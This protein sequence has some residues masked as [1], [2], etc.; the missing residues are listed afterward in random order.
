MPLRE[1]KKALE[2]N[3]ETRR[4]KGVMR[5]VFWLYGENCGAYVDYDERIDGKYIIHKVFL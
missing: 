5:N 2:E 3:P 4:K 1:L